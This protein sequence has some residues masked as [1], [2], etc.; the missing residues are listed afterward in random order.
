MMSSAIPAR[1]EFQCGHAALVT[2]PRI[3]GETAAQRN[4]RVAREKSAAQ[5]RQ[6]D[7]CTPAMVIAPAPGATTAPVLAVETGDHAANGTG[8]RPAATRRRRQRVLRSAP[9]LT[10]Q[11]IA[12]PVT[13]EPPIVE[14]ATTVVIEEPVIAPKPVRSPRARRAPVVNGAATHVRHQFTVHYQAEQVITADTVLDALRQAQTLGARE[15]FSIVSA[16]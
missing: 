11:V 7:F 16:N 13:E 10:E 14:T 4:D 1:L 15:V 6:C 9:V 5:S 12:P 3:K 2:L 8:T